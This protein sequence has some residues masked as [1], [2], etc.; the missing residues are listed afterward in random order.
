MNCVYSDKVK[1]ELRAWWYMSPTFV[2]GEQK[3]TKCLNNNCNTN[4]ETK[5]KN[6]GAIRNKTSTVCSN[7]C[8]DTSSVQITQLRQKPFS[9]LFFFPFGALRR[10][11]EIIE[12]TMDSYQA[13]IDLIG[14]K[15]KGTLKLKYF[16]NAWR[17]SF[18]A[19]TNCHFQLLCLKKKNHPVN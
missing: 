10:L 6:S 1:R 18:M 16:A 5:T 7:W 8:H 11:T 14:Q 12:C 4:V 19:M 2:C 17:K 9:F 3:T 15:K 13:L